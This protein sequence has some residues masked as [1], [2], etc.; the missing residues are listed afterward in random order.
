[1]SLPADDPVIELVQG[2]AINCTGYGS[3]EQYDILKDGVRVGYA[4]LRHGYFSV[5]VNAGDDDPVYESSE[6][7][8]DGRFEEWERKYF[9]VRGV[10]ALA[11]FYRMVEKVRSGP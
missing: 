5:W 11:R 9:L 10:L 6:V 2:Y 7:N 4:R 8:G 1:M 3:P